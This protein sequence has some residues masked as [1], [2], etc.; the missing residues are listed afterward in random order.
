MNSNK[1]SRSDYC[2][3]LVGS[4]KLWKR[5]LNVQ[6]PYKRAIRNMQLGKTLEIGCGIGRVLRWL[7]KDSVGVDHNP[8]SIGICLSRDL[9][10]YTTENFVEAVKS[11]AIKVMSFDSLL[12]SHVLEH[13]EPFEQVEII[14]SYLPYLKRNGV[15]FLITPQEIGFSS[16]ETH[17][18]FTDFN[19][20]NE[21]LNELNFEVISQKSFPFPR[22]FGKYFRYNEFHT[23]AKHG[24]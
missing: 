2:E 15:I 13:L 11:E 23:Y 19:R 4:N 8:T 22:S 17:I 24:T 1:T 7:P 21:I 10:A 12:L 3:Y 9:N 14:N 20:T 5:I 18:T 6:Y 16:D